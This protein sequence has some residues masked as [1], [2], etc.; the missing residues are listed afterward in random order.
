D[1]AFPGAGLTQLGQVQAD[2]I[3]GAL[4]EEDIA[5]IYASTLV[6]TQKTA[7]PLAQAR[8]LE[9]H[10]R[11]GLEEVSAGDLELRSD[12]EAVQTY[13]DCLAGWM[14]GDLSRAMPGATTG[15][16]FLK[17]Y[18]GA[19]DAVAGEHGIDDTVVIVSHGA[20]IRVFAAYAADLDPDVATEARI[21]N[22]GMATFEGHPSTGWSL[23][24]WLTTP[25]GGEAL[26][27]A[28]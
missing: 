16:E 7:Q 23:S 12:N 13:A 5:G 26:T 18:W 22:T 10:V 3:P 1:T 6:R 8:G 11:D 19:V 9:V 24:A 14:V 25:L 27:D 21:L 4:H 15:H 28:R 17:R 20:A 2:A